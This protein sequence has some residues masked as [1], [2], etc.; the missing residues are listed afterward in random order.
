MS[1]VYV[2]KLAFTLVRCESCGNE[3]AAGER[4]PTCGA[5]PTGGD[6]DVERRRRMVDRARPPLEH[7][8]GRAQRIAPAEVFDELGKWPGGFLSAVQRV[9]EG[10]EVEGANRL[11]ASLAS[12]RRIADRVAAT[13]RKK[14]DPVWTTI[15]GV[16]AALRG[17][18]DS[19]LAALTAASPHEAQALGAE[20][21]RQMDSAGAIANNLSVQ[22]AEERGFWDGVVLGAIGGWL[23]G[24]RR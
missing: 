4:C 10:T 5:A 15:D 23:W 7:A 21:Q 17:A 6:P 18:I 24:H 3:R 9:S 16:L 22:Q 12:F 2:F 13:P 19:Y 8:S 14:P 1:S 20:A 11:G